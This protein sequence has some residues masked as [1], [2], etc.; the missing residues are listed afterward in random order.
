MPKDVQGMGVPV[1]NQRKQL[2]GFCELL[3]TPSRCQVH[4][5]YSEATHVLYQ[6]SPHLVPCEII[7]PGNCGSKPRETINLVVGV[8]NDQAREQDA[9]HPLNVAH[10]HQR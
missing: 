1:P 3:P 9:A 10:L 7:K 8:A 6:E 2:T 5:V 4:H